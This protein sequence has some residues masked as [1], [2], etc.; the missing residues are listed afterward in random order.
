MKRNIFV[1]C[2]AKPLPFTDSLSM[3][4]FMRT[5]EESNGA[6]TLQFIS[7][8]M[9]SMSSFLPFIP[10]DQGYSTSDGWIFGIII[11]KF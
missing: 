8:R 9:F 6:E 1:G 4:K 3:G 11:W 2:G 7:F 5:G 10:S